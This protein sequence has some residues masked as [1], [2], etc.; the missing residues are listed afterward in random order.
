M[1]TPDISTGFQ[2]VG[3][4]IREA[5]GGK[6]PTPKFESSFSSEL[7]SLASSTS[8]LRNFQVKTDLYLVS[9]IVETSCPSY[10]EVK[11]D[12]GKLRTY[13]LVRVTNGSGNSWM[14]PRDF[15]DFE[16]LH[17]ALRHS[18]VLIDIFDFPGW[19][20]ITSDIQKEKR[21]ATFD[22]YVRLV[23]QQVRESGKSQK[24]ATTSPNNSIAIPREVAVFLM[25]NQ[26]T[27][28]TFINFE[29][30]KPSS[31]ENC[32]CQLF[33]G[34]KERTY[35]IFSVTDDRGIQSTCSKT[36]TDFAKLFESVKTRCGEIPGF[37]FPKRGFWGAASVQ[38]K[39]TR[40]K[41]FTLLSNALVLQSP[42]LAETL[43]FF[44]GGL[45]GM[46]LAV[47]II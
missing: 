14:V 40:S 34:N 47:K 27:S 39:N 2:Q 38:E 4:F 35:Y 1:N 31:S 37:E 25:P 18:H 19:E 20:I 30:R 5:I 9:G 44:E 33:G 3:D 41:M 12:R 21:R 28:A 13:Y 8:A 6:S 22:H 36:Y 11:D 17:H 29:D 10:A 16:R 15:D 43:S 32:T 45:P 42:Q 46:N 7:V 23:L 24:S 26:L